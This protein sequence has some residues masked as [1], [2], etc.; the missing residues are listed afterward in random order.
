MIKKDID[1]LIHLGWTPS[2]YFNP[3][4]KD[5]YL[6]KVFEVSQAKELSDYTDYTPLPGEKVFLAYELFPNTETA[7]CCLWSENDNPAD[8]LWETDDYETVVELAL[9]DRLF[10]YPE[11]RKEG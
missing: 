7:L 4:E 5:Y 8:V 10:T 6:R 1:K 11:N 3:S 2:E 9:E